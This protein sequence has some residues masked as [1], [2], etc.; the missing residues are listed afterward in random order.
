[1]VVEDDRMV[2][3]A[4]AREL[5]TFE[6]FEAESC[7]EAVQALIAAPDIAAVVCDRFLGAGGD[8][9]DLLEDLREHRPHVARILVSGSHNPAEA[10][11]AVISGLAHLSI[12]KP[13]DPCQVRAAVA[14]E[15]AKRS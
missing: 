6:V 12:D 11:E 8:G 14:A 5:R 9:F 1:L 13:W 15:I 7:H 3:R 10:R 4:L 2:R